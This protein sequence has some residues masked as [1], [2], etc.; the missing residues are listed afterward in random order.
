MLHLL[1]IKFKNIKWANF[2]STGAQFTEV[3]FDKSPTTLIIGEMVQV[4]LLF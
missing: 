2:L 4:S 1:M 3:R